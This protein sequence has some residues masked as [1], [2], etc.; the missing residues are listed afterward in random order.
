LALFVLANICFVYLSS[1][2]VNSFFG[3]SLKASKN[4]RKPGKLI[5]YEKIWEM[6]VILEDLR[7]LSVYRYDFCLLEL[8]ILYYRSTPNSGSK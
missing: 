5:D 7:E 8:P 6:A 1:K 2:S 3:F 4:L